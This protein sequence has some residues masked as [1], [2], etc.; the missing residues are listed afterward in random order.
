RWRAEERSRDGGNATDLIEH[1][2]ARSEHHPRRERDDH[3]VGDVGADPAQ[4]DG[5]GDERDHENEEMADRRRRRAG[6]EQL[7]EH[8]HIRRAVGPG[9]RV[10]VAGGGFI[11]RALPWSAWTATP[12]PR[13][14]T[15]P[16]WAPKPRRRT[17]NECSTRPPS[18]G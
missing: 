11:R 7:R 2:A 17:W 8:L 10:P 9:E 6:G 13:A 4:R 12:S 15:T 14:S 1:V 18:T 16:F 5:D 3:P